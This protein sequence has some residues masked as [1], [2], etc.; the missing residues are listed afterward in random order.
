MAGTREVWEEVKRR[1]IVR[2]I[3]EHPGAT[4]PAAAAAIEDRHEEIGAMMTVIEG[5]R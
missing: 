1:L 3:K 5:E 2:Y 4:W